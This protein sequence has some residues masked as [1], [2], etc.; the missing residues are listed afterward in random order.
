I[1]QNDAISIRI[2][3]RTRRSTTASAGAAMHENHV[4]AIRM[5]ALFVIQRV[6]IGYRQV[7]AGV[8]FD[9]RI[10][11]M[12]RCCHGRCGSKIWPERVFQDVVGKICDQQLASPSTRVSS[13]AAGGGQGVAPQ[14]R[15][16]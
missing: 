8:G 15:A 1:E 6:D 2:E 14:A 9:R 13:S 16:M 4:L 12:S 11:R 5:A 3:E 7:S 10:G